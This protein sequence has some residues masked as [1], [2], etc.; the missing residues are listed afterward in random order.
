MTHL[1]CAGS[2]TRLL[3]TWNDLW[4]GLVSERLSGDATCAA[5][6]GGR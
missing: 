5:E 2:G 6:L 3:E 4:H 1:L